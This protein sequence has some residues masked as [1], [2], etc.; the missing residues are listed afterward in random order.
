MKKHCHHETSFASKY[1]KNAFAA[2]LHPA[3]PDPLA[4]LE[5][6]GKGKEGKRNE[7]RERRGK[8]GKGEEGEERKEGKRRTPKRKVWLRSCTT[9]TVPPAHASQRSNLKTGKIHSRVY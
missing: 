7:V 4:G 9:A 1:P 8:E 5:N 6:G 2:G 3:L